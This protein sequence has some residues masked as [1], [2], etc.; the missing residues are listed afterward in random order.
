[1]RNHRRTTKLSAILIGSASAMA[2]SI[3]SADAL[4]TLGNH[5]D[6]GSPFPFAGG[7]KEV[8]FDL[9]N[10]FSCG[11]A[12]ITQLGGPDFGF[13]IDF[14]SNPSSQ[15]ID[16]ASS[17]RASDLVSQ[18][19]QSASAPF[20]NQ[21]LPFTVTADPLFLITGAFMEAGAGVKA[22]FSFSAEGEDGGEDSGGFADA[23][24]DV[25][26]TLSNGGVLADFSTDFDG[27]VGDSNVDGPTGDSIDTTGTAGPAGGGLTPANSQNLLLA[28]DLSQSTTCDLS[29]TSGLDC[30]AQSSAF[31]NF[32]E[33]RFTQ[34]AAP[35][36]VDVPEPATMGL[37]GAGLAGLAWFGWRRRKRKG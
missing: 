11:G 9:T 32:I 21:L 10:C 18:D 8:F 31:I 20:D 24:G 26:L 35:K 16:G 27:A 28:W 3:G 34:E 33:V 19:T 23:S 37:F 5:A 15:E 30:N 14:G 2:L 29:G 13:R 1:M 7:E 25:N 36:E 6:P 22:S 4:T 17:L 12:G